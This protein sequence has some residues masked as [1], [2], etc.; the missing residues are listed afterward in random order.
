M[1]VCELETPCSVAH[2]HETR[3]EAGVITLIIGHIVRVRKY[4]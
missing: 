3:S 1:F 4:A 2:E